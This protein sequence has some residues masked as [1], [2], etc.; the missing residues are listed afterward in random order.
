MKRDTYIIV[1]VNWQLVPASIDY[2]GH[3]DTP[4]DLNLRWAHF[5]DSATT[6]SSKREAIREAKRLQKTYS[7]HQIKVV[8][9]GGCNMVWNGKPMIAH[10]AMSDFA[11]K[12][13][14]AK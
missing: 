8:G 13:G 10:S 9:Y 3:G 11:V 1:R 7:G 12:V 5:R 4:Y 2:V 6:W 14:V